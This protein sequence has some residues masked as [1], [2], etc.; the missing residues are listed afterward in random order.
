MVGSFRVPTYSRLRVHKQDK[1]IAPLEFV[2]LSQTTNKAGMLFLVTFDIQSETP[3]FLEGCVRAKIDSSNETTFL[4]SGT[5]DFF[6]SAFYFNRGEYHGYHSGLTYKAQNASSTH[7]VAYKFFVDD[8]VLFSNSFKL[9][10]RNFEQSKGPDGCPDQFPPNP[11]GKESDLTRFGDPAK[12]RIQ[13]YAW[14]YE[15]DNY[16]GKFNV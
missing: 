2:Q 15:W 11:N 3:A 5:E 7:I 9:I 16:A 6:L 13:S 14:V 12:A 8:P 1:T 10:W 4:S